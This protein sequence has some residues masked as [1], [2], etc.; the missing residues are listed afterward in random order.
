MYNTAPAGETTEN[1]CPAAG[2]RSPAAAANLPAAPVRLFTALALTAAAAALSGCASFP[3]SEEYV[4]SAALLAPADGAGVRRDARAEFRRVFCALVDQ[5]DSKLGTE[6]GCDEYLWQLDDEPA[7]PAPAPLQPLAPALRVFIVGG[8]FSDCFGD[9]SVAYGE[10]VT[11]LAAEGIRITVVPISGRSSAYLNASR[12]AET[13]ARENPSQDE[14]VVLIGYSKGTV[15][16][17]HFLVR[18]PATSRTVDAVIS[19]SGPVH[20]S[21]AA[22]RGAWL[23]DALLANRFAGM[24][25]PGDGGV[26]DSLVPEYRQAWLGEH[27][28]PQHVRYYTLSAFTTREHMA[29]G[30]VPT[31]RLL[32]RLDPRNDGQVTLEE[33]LLPG[34]TLLGYANADH[35]SLAIDIEEELEFFAS[36]PDKRRFPREVLFE[37]LLRFVSNDLED[38]DGN[39]R[40]YTPSTR[41][42]GIPEASAAEVPKK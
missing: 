2:P 26:V 5:A 6:N 39:S 23:Y 14:L 25:E 28:L 10:A 15:D 1:R 31:Y 12:I 37:A 41:S 33:G 27:D 19:V 32:A 40:P 3:S 13:Y 35:W 22:R 9:A 29:R 16:I 34:S 21:E 11:R 8:A 18:Y 36:R 17:L 4:H 7:G 24:C 30:L 20:G 38:G 42:R